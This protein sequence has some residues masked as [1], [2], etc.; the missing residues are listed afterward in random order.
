MVFCDRNNANCRVSRILGIPHCG[1]SERKFWYYD[2]DVS[3]LHFFLYH[4]LWIQTCAI[5]VH[6]H[7]YRHCL[8]YDYCPGEL[9]RLNLRAGRASS[10]R[11]RCHVNPVESEPLYLDISSLVHHQVLVAAWC[12]PTDHQESHKPKI[13]KL[14][15]RL[16]FTS[17]GWGYL[18]WK[19]SRVRWKI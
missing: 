7:L 14:A 18:L 15:T 12:V 9:L 17:K 3:F 13:I 1:Q 19:R 2:R 6:S 8:H 5:P 10:A 16:L 4:L 11:L